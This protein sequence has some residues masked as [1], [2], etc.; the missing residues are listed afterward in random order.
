MLFTSLILALFPSVEAEPGICPNYY[1]PYAQNPIGQSE[2]CENMILPGVY[3]VQ[4][5]HGSESNWDWQHWDQLDMKENNRYVLT[6]DFNGK[7]SIEEYEDSSLTGYTLICGKNNGP[8]EIVFCLK[9]ASREASKTMNEL[10]MGYE[11]T[12]YKVY[13]DGNYVGTDGENGDA[14]DGN[15]K[16]HDIPCLGNH[17]I[18]VDDGD[19][20]HTLDFYFGCGE[21]YSINV[22]DPLFVLE[23]SQ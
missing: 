10:L 6:Y 5:A 20:T 11:I 9:P 12:G 19:L 13:L 17:S 16:V 8:D 4:W 18:V 22:G 2:Y 21:S 1:G 7:L 23:K 14:L 15:F 3:D